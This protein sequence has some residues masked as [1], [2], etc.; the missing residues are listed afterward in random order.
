M[1]EHISIK[2]AQDI[3]KKG[4]PGNVLYSFKRPKYMKEVETNGPEPKK[5]KP[6]EQDPSGIYTQI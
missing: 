6:S 2:E 1:P 3:I 4:R 5:A